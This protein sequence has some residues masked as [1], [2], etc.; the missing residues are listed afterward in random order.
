[1]IARRPGTLEP[2]V[3][4]CARKGTVPPH[5]I[6]LAAKIALPQSELDQLTHLNR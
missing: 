5:E 4:T 2:L 1:L 3:T 6:A